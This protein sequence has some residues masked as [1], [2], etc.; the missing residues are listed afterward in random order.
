MRTTLKTATVVLAS[1]A[2]LTLSAGSGPAVAKTVDG[3]GITTGSTQV[4][5]DS[6]GAA[7]FSQVNKLNA[8]L[9]ELPNAGIGRPG[10]KN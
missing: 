3:A 7:R 9:D 4:A 5:T 10:T 2:L 6:G 8:M 1:A